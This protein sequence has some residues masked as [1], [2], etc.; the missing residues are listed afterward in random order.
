[1][2]STYTLIA[3]NVITGTPTTVTFSSILSTY[4]DLILR[5][6]LRTTNASAVESLQIR[7]NGNTSGI[8]SLTKIYAGLGNPVGSDRG[9]GSNSTE[10][11][12]AAGADGANNTSNT[13]SSYELYIPNYTVSQNKPM[14]NN[15]AVEGNSTT[16][17]FLAAQAD[18]FRSTSA[19]DSIAITAR[20]GGT[21]FVAGSS[22]YL[23]GIK[24][25]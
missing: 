8:Y 6:S 20:A 21:N 13:F 5:A 7:F 2:P 4:T 24:N 23:Y 14:S 19:I 18:L 11:F 1:M 25:S 12:I 10:M 22:F 16:D 9:L 17:Y 3:S 15:W